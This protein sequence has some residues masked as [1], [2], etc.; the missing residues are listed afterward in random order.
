MSSF[1]N[2]FM[3]TNKYVRFI[4]TVLLGLVI[5]TSLIYIVASGNSAWIVLPFVL[6]VWSYTFGRIILLIAS[7]YTDNRDFKR[8]TEDLIP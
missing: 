1:A 6:G 2:W 7:S 5:T 4:L 3:T 8:H